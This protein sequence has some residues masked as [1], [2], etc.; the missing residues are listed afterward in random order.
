MF[1]CSVQNVLNL[2]MEKYFLKKCLCTTSVSYGWVKRVKFVKGKVY[3]LERR[4]PYTISVLGGKYNDFVFE[5]FN[6]YFEI[7]KE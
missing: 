7:V 1:W 4:G 6:D 2:C 5:S 3:W